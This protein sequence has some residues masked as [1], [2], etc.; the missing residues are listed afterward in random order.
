M[1]PVQA[2]CFHRQ[3]K[4]LD[5]P[6]RCYKPRWTYLFHWQVNYP[7]STSH[8]YLP[9]RPGPKHGPLEGP[10]PGSDIPHKCFALRVQYAL[11][12]FPDAEPV[13]CFSACPSNS[14]VAPSGSL[15]R[16]RASSL[17]RVQSPP[18][19]LFLLDSAPTDVSDLFIH[20]RY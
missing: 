19:P 2:C 8:A 18:G 1:A 9:S 14:R 16:P 10:L 5:R 13:E 3:W 7:L 15:R 11:G 17:P 12:E 20:E 4:A 6:P